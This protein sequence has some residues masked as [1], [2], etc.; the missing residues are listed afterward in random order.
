MAE[1]DAPTLSP[2]QFGEELLRSFS[3]EA[4]RDFD[5]TVQFVLQAVDSTAPRS[6]GFC[7]D[8]G[9]IDA[10][11]AG[12]EPFDITLYFHTAQEALDLLQGQANPVEAF[13]D[14]RFRSDGYLLW[15]FA[16]LS[17]FRGR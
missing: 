11:S 15:V 3:A 6:I 7:I 1:I 10:R 16:V 13:M 14:G 12:T 2:S 17:M 8:H 4:A 9:R 5:G